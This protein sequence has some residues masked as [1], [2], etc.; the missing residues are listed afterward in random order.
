MDQLEFFDIPS[1]CIGVCEANSKGFCKGCFRS[2]EER[3]YWLEFTTE[4][5][6][7]VVR[8]CQSRQ[9]RVLRARQEAARRQQTDS[10]TQS[11]LF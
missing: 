4:Q 9:A 5:K 8:L 11:E 10:D 1:P 7:Q 6:R 2:R 3:L